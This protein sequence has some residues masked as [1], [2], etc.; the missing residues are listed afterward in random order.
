[1][2]EPTNGQKGILP[3][4]LTPEEFD[5]DL[6]GWV[7]GLPKTA[8]ELTPMVVAAIGE[9]AAG[10]AKVFPGLLIGI[11]LDAVT[12]VLRFND[13]QYW[14]LTASEGGVP[15][16]PILQVPVLSEETPEA[17]EAGGQA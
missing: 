11:S 9:Y 7:P 12:V 17:G 1:M 3:G 13:G 15:F 14:K 16:L 10:L 4:V 6:A 5:P 8:D 2:N